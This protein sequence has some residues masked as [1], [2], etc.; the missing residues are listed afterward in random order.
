M[1]N[2]VKI[3][4][5]V[6]L[7]FTMIAILGHSIIPHHHHFNVNHEQGECLHD[8]VYSDD[9]I[10]QVS[11]SSEQLCHET[12]HCTE[13][14]FSADLT[15]PSSAFSFYLPLE[16]ISLHCFHKEANCAYFAS[17]KYWKPSTFLDRTYLRGPPLL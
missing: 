11:L 10:K 7:W 5:I 17:C 8:H 3:I 15:H 6:S 9:L 16:H 13:C 4:A 2:K 14:H 12:E 1:N